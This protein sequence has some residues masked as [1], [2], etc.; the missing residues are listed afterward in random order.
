MLQKHHRIKYGKHEVYNI[1]QGLSSDDTIQLELPPGDACG[2]GNRTTVMELV[3]DKNASKPIIDTSEFNKDNCHHKIIMRT[4]GACPV[5]KYELWY[6]KFNVYFTGIVLGVLGLVYM[7]FGFK[8]EIITLPLLILITTALIVHSISPNIPIIACV[9]FGLAFV[10]LTHL[11]ERI[12]YYVIIFILSNF[13]ASFVFRGLIG[14]FLGN[15][16]S[17]VIYWV[18]VG[19]IAIFLIIIL[20][21]IENLLKVIITSIVGAFLSVRV[22]CF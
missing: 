4:K 19:V 3:C 7:I 10:L 8:F 20:N 15:F 22:I 2:D 18:T 6:E 12:I 17:D 16:D 9:C 14:Y 5:T 13:L 1:N 11:F 21:L